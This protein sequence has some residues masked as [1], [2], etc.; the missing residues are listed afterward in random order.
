M[1]E[2]AAHITVTHDDGVQNGAFIGFLGRRIP[3]GLGATVVTLLA[4]LIAVTWV[5]SLVAT[6]TNNG[7][8][9]LPLF[10]VTVAGGLVL[11]AAFYGYKTLAWLFPLVVS[12]FWV[13]VSMTH[14][15]PQWQVVLQTITV[16]AT[17]FATVWA[18]TAA[19]KAEQ[20]RF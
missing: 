8:A 12:A 13:W 19:H 5:W 15:T 9:F 2:T 3:A 4:L 14:L 17:L 6:W 11:G 16:T 1:T 20:P 10:P 7:D 18:V